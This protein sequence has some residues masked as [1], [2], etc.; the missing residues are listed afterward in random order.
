MDAAGLAIQLLKA[1]EAAE[2][3]SRARS[4]L[5][6][7]LSHDVRTVVYNII[8]MTDGVLATELKPEQRTD[9]SLV[10]DSANA[11]LRIMDDAFE[12]LK[13]EER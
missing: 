7:N 6:A 2:A 11:L 5:L 13:I 4:E 1:K 12:W 3:A 10:K 9:L 8:G